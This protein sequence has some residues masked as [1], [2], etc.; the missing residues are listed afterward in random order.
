LTGS[1]A[2]GRAVGADCGKLTR[3]CTL[4]LGGKSAAIFCDDG[5][6]DAFRAGLATTSFKNN[7][8]TCTTQ[9]RILAPRSRDGEVV[10]AV[11]EYCKGRQFAVSGG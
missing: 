10:D 5:D 2:A 8:Q 6:I 3:R 4:E 11:A 7:S 1:T 9:S